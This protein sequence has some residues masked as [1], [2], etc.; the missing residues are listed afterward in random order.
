M[1]ELSRIVG[2][3]DRGLARLKPPAWA[4]D[5]AGEYMMA[6][7]D[8]GAALDN[9]STELSGSSFTATD[10]KRANAKLVRAAKLERRRFKRLAREIGAIPTVPGDR[11]D[12][13]ETPAGDDTQSA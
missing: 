10:Y 5:E 2:I 4:V 9:F 7:S 11:G 12:G 6:L 13:D 8:L 1:Q 3:E